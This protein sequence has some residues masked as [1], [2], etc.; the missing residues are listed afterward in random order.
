MTS[1]D[2]LVSNWTA[3]DERWQ[4]YLRVLSPGSLD[5][6]VYKVSTS[7]GYGK[8]HGTRRGD[9]LLHV[10]TH[11]QYTAAQAINMLRHVGVR[12]LPDVMLIT[13]ARSE[14]SGE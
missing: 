9:V 11:A 1:L 4:S 5:D 12:S 6:I 7:S 14:L 10:C 3:L 8:R 2:E 13:L